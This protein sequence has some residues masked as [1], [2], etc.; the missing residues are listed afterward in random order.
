[1]QNFIPHFIY[2][3]YK[4][5]NFEGEFHS[6][7]MFMDISGFTP[8]TEKLMNYGKEGA[9]VLSDI[10]NNIFKPVVHSIYK[11][12]GFISGF[13]GDALTAIFPI[14]HRKGAEDF[15]YLLKPC[16]AA[17][18]IQKIFEKKGLQKTK[19]ADFDLS[20]KVGLSGGEVHWGIVGSKQHKTYLFR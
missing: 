14:F 13:A 7:T 1:M 9:E 6:I 19:F 18:A 20:V 11:R 8:M 16:F 5:N 3:Q 17:L 15:S 4:E 10:L 2:N 12:G